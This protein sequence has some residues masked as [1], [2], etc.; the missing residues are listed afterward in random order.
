MRYAL[1]LAS[2][3]LLS[4]SAPA[5]ANAGVVCEAK[6]LC[7]SDIEYLFMGNSPMRLSHNRDKAVDLLLKLRNKGK[8]RLPQG[9]RE[10][11]IKWLIPNI[12]YIRH[13]YLSGN[14]VVTDR[15]RDVLMYCIESNLFRGHPKV[16]HSWREARE[17]AGIIIP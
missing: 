16:G 4:H 1:I 6:R 14:Y 5:L 3:C 17:V 8:A 11:I 9:E 15:F 2:L 7:D 13:N 10:K 12:D